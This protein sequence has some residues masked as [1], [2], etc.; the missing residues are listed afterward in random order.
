MPAWTAPPDDMPMRLAACNACHGSDG[1]GTTG[2]EYYPHLAGKP[3]GY[4]L[5]QLQAFRDGRR[6]YPQMNWLMRNMGDQYLA[7]IA[8]YYARLPPRSSAVPVPMAPADAQRARQLV[9]HGDPRRGVPACASCHGDDLAGLEPGVPALLGLPPD[10]IT[11]QLGAWRTGTR[12]ATAPDC[13]A[14]I[15]RALDPADFR[16]LGN[17]LASQGAGGSLAPAPAESFTLPR[18]C[19]DMRGDPARE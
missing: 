2:N 6:I 11:A 9:A 14:K 19:G 13:M 3:T 7:W 4:L 17:W 10:Y 16:R 1:E 15:A 18:D 5:S 8:D 12:T